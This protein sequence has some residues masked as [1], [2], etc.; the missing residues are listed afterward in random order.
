[1]NQYGAI[2]VPNVRLV[3][4]NHGTQ[5]K[6]IDLETVKAN[7]EKEKVQSLLSQEGLRKYF[8]EILL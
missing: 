5:I 1:M 3:F 7:Y 6:T 2:E 4:F 8:V